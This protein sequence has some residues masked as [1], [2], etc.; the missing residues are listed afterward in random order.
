MMLRKISR[1]EL[2]EI[3]RLHSLWLNDDPDG[4]I[5]DLR[6][7]N[8]SGVDLQDADLRGANLSGANLLGAD[9]RDADLRDADLCRADL[10]GADLRDADLRGAKLNQSIPGSC[11]IESSKWFRSDIP[12]WIGH[13]Q[14]GEIIL[15]DD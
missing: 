13:R 4:L 5:A 6:G 10:L 9:L 11:W 2:Q 7:A 15:C 3:L 8:L 1:K 12:W 14:Q